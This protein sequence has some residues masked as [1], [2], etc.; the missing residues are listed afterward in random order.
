MGAYHRAVQS[1]HQLRSVKTVLLTSSLTV[2][3]LL[4]RAF[5]IF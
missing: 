5:E 2:G 1:G 4:L 3:L